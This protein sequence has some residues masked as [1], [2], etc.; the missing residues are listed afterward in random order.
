MT[1]PTR[2]GTT[3]PVDDPR[4][5]QTEDAG[6]THAADIVGRTGEE[7]PVQRHAQVHDTP[8]PP[9]ADERTRPGH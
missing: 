4:D 8:D 1:T 9:D 2:T 7:M 5:P 6:D 3:A